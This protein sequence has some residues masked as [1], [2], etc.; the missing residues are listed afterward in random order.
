MNL[1]KTFVATLG[2]KTKSYKLKSNSIFDISINDLSG[3]AIDLSD[4]KGKYILFV[5]VA[6]K[7]GFTPQYTD[8]QKLYD[9]YK[10]KLQIIGIPC[11][12]FRNQEPGNS[13]DIESFCKVNYGVTFLI[14][15][16]IK[17]KGTSKH[18]LYKWLTEKIN[19]GVKDST[20]RW[21]F[22]K[23]LVNPQGQFLDYYLSTTNPTSRKITRHLE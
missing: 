14:T 9:T 17:V 12:Q 13:N 21:N 19:N 18:N 5:N 22:Q 1:L 10:D 7:C 4:F 3:N 15:E 11:N 8:L 6:S 23:Y 20:V 16:K 2:T